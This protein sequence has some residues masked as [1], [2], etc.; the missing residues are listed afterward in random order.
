MKLFQKFKN[1]PMLMA[2]AMLV[3]SASLAGFGQNAA[4]EAPAGFTTYSLSEDPGSTSIGNGL[5]EPNGVTFTDNQAHFEETD[6][7]DNGL[8]PIYNAQSCANCHQ[9]P[10]VGGIS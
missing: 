6:G 3:L 5:P 7:M 4:T 9:N 8:G 2:G 1:H 10:V